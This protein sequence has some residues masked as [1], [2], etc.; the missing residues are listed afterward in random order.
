MSHINRILLFSRR[1]R[2]IKYVQRTETR[3]KKNRNSN[4]RRAHPEKT[5]WKAVR[6]L[7]EYSCK[8]IEH[9]PRSK[10]VGRTALTPVDGKWKTS[11]RQ[12]EEEMEEKKS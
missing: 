5:E 12:K 4:Q 3:K 7:F 11:R 1:T 9:F 2:R 10:V 8:S 6:E